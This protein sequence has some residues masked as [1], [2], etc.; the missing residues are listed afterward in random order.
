[1]QREYG[2]VQGRVI[3]EPDDIG[4]VRVS[5]NW[6]EGKNE[7]Y[8]ASIATPMTG[9]GRGMYYMPEVGD[10]VLV[11]FEHGNIE[12][13]FIIG[14]LWNGDD[15]PPTSDRRLRLIHSVNGHEIAIYDPPITSGDM[16]YVR[17]RD[18]QGNEVTLSNASITIRS[19]GMIN[20][21]APSVVINGRAVL[22]IPKPI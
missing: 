17:L 4:R 19:V 13:P 5:L 7:T 22:P 14:F 3:S 6:L 12:F 21:Q 18:A 1:M 2:V 10:D 8:W 20:I 9:S 16:G 11:V 15:K